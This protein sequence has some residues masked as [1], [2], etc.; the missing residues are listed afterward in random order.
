VVTGLNGWGFT[1]AAVIADRVPALLDGRPA[2][3][4]DGHW[5]PRWQAE[6]IVPRGG[7]GDAAATMGW[8]GRSLVG[9]H[10]AALVPA[11][12]GMRP[13]EGR[14]VG[15]PVSPRA[16]CVTPDGER[17]CVSARCTHLGCLVR[18]NAMELSWD[19]PCHGSRFAPDGRVLEGPA[20]APLEP[21][22][23]PG[24]DG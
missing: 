20:C 23:A 10:L 3:R 14:I 15:G 21:R 13:G 7:L 9:D 19:C 5:A 24:S 4:P 8:V 2:H 1:N 16:M 18:W 11:A 22:D 12:D 17:H 6:R